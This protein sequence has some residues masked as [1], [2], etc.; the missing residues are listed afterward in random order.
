MNIRR[1]LFRAWALI[2]ILWIGAVTFSPLFDWNYAPRML[3]KGSPSEET[4]KVIM[5]PSTP[6][7]YNYVASPSAEKLTIEF[8]RSLSAEPMTS[9]HFVKYGSSD[10]TLYIPA[11]YNEADR[12]YIVKQFEQQ[13]WSRW[14]SDI[15]L[16]GVVPCIVLFALGR[17]LLWVGRGFR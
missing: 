11:G 14:M 1:G 6:T 4:T 12:D 8:V 17:A 5:G 16:F 10:G 13:W 7:F 2:S 15:A 9:T 3:I